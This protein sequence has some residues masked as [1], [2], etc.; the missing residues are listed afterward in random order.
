MQ[1]KTRRAARALGK[2]VL[3][4]GAAALGLAILTFLFA[5]LTGGFDARLGLDW[6]RRVLYVIGGVCVVVSGA[7]LFFAGNAPRDQRIG[8]KKD[9]TLSAFERAGD[10]LAL[11]APRGQRGLLPAGRH[12]RPAA[13]RRSVGTALLVDGRLGKLING[14][15]Q[16]AREVSDR[17]KLRPHDVIPPLLVQLNHAETHARCLGELL[18]R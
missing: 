18:L 11:V 2:A 5:F 10:Q 15:A 4:G 6:A 12:S 17:R 8:F 9:E 1:E 7:G 3:Y 13:R 14:A 16:G